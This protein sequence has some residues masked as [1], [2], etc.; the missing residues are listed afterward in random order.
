MGVRGVLK[1]ISAIMQECNERIECDPKI[2]V[3]WNFK[4]L[5]LNYQGKYGEAIEAYNKA[6]ELAP[7]WNVPRHNKSI[8]HQELSWPERAQ[9]KTWCKPGREMMLEEQSPGCSAL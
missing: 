2:A 9:I 4:G 3:S 6:I 8:A 5:A 7:E 1:R